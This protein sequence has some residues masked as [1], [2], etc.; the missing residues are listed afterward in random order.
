MQPNTAYGVRIR[1]YAGGENS[2]WSGK[3]VVTTDKPHVAPSWSAV[4]A[5]PAQT[6]RPYRL[7]LAPFVDGYPAPVLSVSAGAAKPEGATL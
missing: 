3:A 1:A 4:A 7:D 2:D 6:G 5:P